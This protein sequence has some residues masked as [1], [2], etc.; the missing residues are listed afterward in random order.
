MIG[1]YPDDIPTLQDVSD[2]QSE[3]RLEQRG[4]L[5][6]VQFPILLHQPI[7]PSVYPDPRSAVTL[8]VTDA[9]IRRIAL[10]GVGRFLDNLAH[11]IE[12]QQMH[13]TV[14]EQPD[15]SQGITIGL[16]AWLRQEPT[17]VTRRRF[18]YRREHRTKI[19][20]VCSLVEC[21]P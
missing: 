19:Y 8:N 2:V 3:E 20:H 12:G 18:R 13:L 4:D 5:F 9:D 17:D 16:H 14:S 7:Q 11:F 6:P 10:I 21:H 15:A 1:R